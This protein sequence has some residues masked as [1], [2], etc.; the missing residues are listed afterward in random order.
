M[1]DDPPAYAGPAPSN[2]KFEDE[3]VW[4]C[5]ECKEFYT[6]EDFLFTTED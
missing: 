2:L 6:E 3:V 4:W 5:P 1:T